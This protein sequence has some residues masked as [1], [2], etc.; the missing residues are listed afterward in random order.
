MQDDQLIEL[1]AARNT[2]RQIE[3]FL[4]YHRINVPAV[5]GW[6]RC[7]RCGKRSF[8][9]LHFDEYTFRKHVR[10]EDLVSIGSYD[11]LDG[12]C[13]ACGADMWPQ[14]CRMD[15]T[16]DPELGMY[17][18]THRQDEACPVCLGSSFQ[19]ITRGGVWSGACNNCRLLY[20]SPG[21]R[22]RVRQNLAH[23]SRCRRETLRTIRTL[24]PLLPS[25]AG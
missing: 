12:Y 5:W 2:L 25:L 14:L 21:L 4:I 13:T 23:L 18:P 22:K 15:K 6:S 19:S 24:E 16:L 3:K 8:V 11:I 10:A 20:A 7:N 9:T 1:L 17:T